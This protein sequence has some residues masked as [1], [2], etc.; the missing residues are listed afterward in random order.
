M[1]KE[2]DMDNIPQL[3]GRPMA[4]EAFDVGGMTCAA[5]QAHVEKA[6]SKLPGVT[7]VA[8][9]LLSGSMT[10]DFDESALTD[11]DICTAVDR[12]GYSAA[13]VAEAAGPGSAAASGT[14]ARAARL[15]SPTKKLEATA[16]AMKTRLIVSLA[17]WIPLFYIGMGHMLGWPVPAVFTDPA[18]GMTLALT[19]LVLTIPIV[20]MNRAYFEN[21][22]KSL[23]HGG[24]TMD[25]LIAIG[26][27]ASIAWSVYAMFLMADQ[28]A[29]GTSAGLHAA[30]ATA[31]DNL[32]FESAGTI[33]SLVTV[34]KYLE[35][36]SKS[37]TG[38]AIEKLIDLA[39]K[40]AT[41][42]DEEG[43]E[44][45]VAVEEIQLGQTIL[46]RPG[47]AVP[48][49]GVVLEG[50][51]AVDES[52]LTGESIPVEKAPGDTV[53]AAT[54]N[55]TGS[56][57]FRATR[58]GADTALARIIR[59]VEDANATKAPIA[60]LADKVAGVFVPVVLGI[61]VITFVAWLALTG[62]P[63]EALTSAV[64]VVVISC[65][66]AL[67][68]ATPLAIMVGTGKG[69]EMGVLFKSA[70]ALETLQKVDTVVL[71][72]TGTITKGAPAVTDILP[73]ERPDG[74]PAMSEK[75]LMKL[76]AALEKKS[77][78]PLAEAIMARA[79][80]MGIV[81]R[82]VEDFTAL[83]GRGVTA[84]EGASIVAAGNAALMEEL[85]IEV[86]TEQLEQF[87]RAGKTPLFFAR[88]GRLAGTIAVADEVKPTSAAA[89]RALEG[90]GIKTVMLTGDNALTA[91]A[92]ARSVGVLD[93]VADVMPADKERHVRALQDEGRSVA[94]VGDGI[95][96]SPAL[97]RADVGLAI[98]T[99]A[100]IAKEGADV[101]LMRSDLMDVA[102]AIELSRAVIRNI[103][104]DLFWALFYNACGIP[105][106][107][108]VFF[109]LLGWQLSP[110]FGAAA[111]SLSSL[112]VCAN[113]LR[114]RG[115]K[116]SVTDRIAPITRR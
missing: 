6:V 40:T 21:G 108:G 11:D 67:G 70:E 98:G 37:K 36:R 116:P 35:T 76:A 97:A 20:F 28:L 56:F 5:C 69:A 94:M 14:P 89:V 10:V 42:V 16:R 45:T 73:A 86:P 104:Q 81:A 62:N 48:V 43:G 47:E 96:D 60:R 114:L 26:A 68:L 111:M 18:H 71:D 52:A 106:A 30:H 2:Y 63:N 46:V 39:P 41:I 77:E 109:P 95:N 25:T 38:G 100:D 54:I 44:A 29:A 31:M 92:I 105:L 65:P 9:N 79:D 53:N 58:V 112:C 93:V 17:F 72:K 15:E 113:A 102:R 23:A 107:A 103:K 78:H 99:G 84:R 55:R 12:A 66:C 85:G 101:V 90:L 49:D 75:A 32:Y 91:G 83:P 80:E 74:T 61:A 27:T 57:T 110:M 22:F 115:F 82:T 51:S 33:L 87:A 64:A 13:P 1:Y 7:N 8:V 4:H 34:G 88:N 59:L 19:E 24:P 3:K 50:S